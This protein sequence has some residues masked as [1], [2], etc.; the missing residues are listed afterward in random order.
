VRP[1]AAPT[2]TG[3]NRLSLRPALVCWNGKSIDAA[4]SHEAV[5]E[6]AVATFAY[7][8]MLNLRG[9]QGN[10]DDK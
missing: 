2:I 8:M 5:D 10:Q 9:L 1:P 7:K 6:N 4:R 3:I